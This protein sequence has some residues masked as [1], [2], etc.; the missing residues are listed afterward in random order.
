MN[1]KSLKVV[2]IA[3]VLLVSNISLAA[4]SKADEN[5]IESELNQLFQRAL[6]G[7]AVDLNDDQILYPMA[8]ILRHD[9]KYG[10]F[11][12]ADSENNKKA[13]ISAQVAQLRKMLTELAVADQIKG[14]AMVQ[15]ADIKKNGKHVSTGLT[16]EMEHK[17]GVSI[18]RFLPVTELEENGKKNGKLRFETQL[19]ST[20]LK[21]KTVFSDSITKR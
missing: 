15:Y 7:A 21:P 12:T 20:S 3:T 4:T 10:V 2:L 11:G 13:P 16:F 9:N 18:I 5:R 19:V 6:K 1:F 17:E 14:Y 8:V